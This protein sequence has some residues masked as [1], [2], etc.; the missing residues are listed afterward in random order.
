VFALVVKQYAADP[1]PFVHSADL[2]S[3]Q[4]M[5]YRELARNPLALYSLG[6]SSAIGTV[7]AQLRSELIWKRPTLRSDGWLV[8]P[9]LQRPN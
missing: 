6:G 3:C 4:T 1:A 2:A 7:E 9:S 8:N 5:L